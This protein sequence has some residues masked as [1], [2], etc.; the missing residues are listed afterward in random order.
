M[1]LKYILGGA[2]SGKFTKCLEE[3]IYAEKN[4]KKGI[5]IVPNQFTL[6]AE[7]IFINKIDTKVIFNTEIL[8]FKRLAFKI[9]SE[10]GL[11]NKIP[12]ENMG[13]LMILRKIISNLLNNNKLNY[14]SKSSYSNMGVLEKISETIQELLECEIDIENFEKTLENLNKNEKI[15]LETKEKLND[16][17]EIFKEYK[18]F[19]EKDYISNEEILTILSKK[20]K[21]SNLIKEN[22]TIWIYGF[23]GFS[24]QEFNVI[25][26]LAEKVEKINICFNFNEKDIELNNINIF[27]P[28]YNIKKTI[29]KFQIL[30]IEN[31]N[32]TIEPPEFLN[33]NLRHKENF[34][35]N[36]FSQ[37]YFKYKV[38]P[39][40]KEAKNIEIFSAQNKFLEIEKV[41]QKINYLIK[42][43]GYRYN[44]IAIILA[45]LEYKDYLKNIFNKY[46]IPYFL[47]YKKD[48]NSHPLVQMILSIFDIIIYNWRYEDIFKYL[49]S[50]FLTECNKFE[51]SEEDLYNLENYILKYGIKNNLWKKEFKYGFYENS[52]YNKEKL[53][54]TRISILKSLEK[55]DFKNNKKY[56]VLEISQKIFDFLI[57]LD[58]DKTLNKWEE[59]NKKLFYEEI[60]L[61]STAL[62]TNIQTWN[63][64]CQVI[65]KF[66][67]ILGNEEITIEEYLKILKVGFSSEKIGILPPTQDQT[68]IG[69]FERTRLSEIKIL[70]CLGMNEGIIPKYEENK[71]FISETERAILLQNLEL[72]PQ[73]NIKLATD[74]LQI[75]STLFKAKEKIIFSYSI[76][77]LQGKAKK[78]SFIISKISKIFPK[79]Q[80]E[81]IDKIIFEKNNIYS[82]KAMFE[83][84]FN[85]Y[86]EIDKN[87]EDFL[88]F[89]DIFNYFLK[90][91]EYTQNLIKT[92]LNLEK[93]KQENNATINQELIE[94]LYE[95][96][97]VFSSVTKLEQF[98]KC[99]F[100]YFL[101]YNIEAKER[102]ILKFEALQLGK[103]YHYILEDFFKKI[104][105][106]KKNLKDIT[107]LEIFNIIEN[108]MEKIKNT[109]EIENIFNLSQKYNYFFKRIKKI[110]LMS[111][112]ASFEQIKLEEFFPDALELSFGDTDDK[113]NSLEYIE[114]DL[115]NTYKMLLSGKI[116]RVD[117]LKTNEK[118]YYKII[119]Y[120]S[121]ENSL[122]EEEIYYGI[123]LQLFIYLSS[124]IKNKINKNEV[125][126]LPSAVLY[127]QIK[128]EIE[129]TNN[130]ENDFLKDYKFYG[131]I[132][133]NIQENGKIGPIGEISRGKRSS[134]TKLIEEDKFKSLLKLSDTIAKEI[135]Q[136]ITKGNINI[137][138]YKYSKNT[139]CEYCQ[140]KSICK[141]DILKQDYN[142]FKTLSNESIWE[143]I[144]EKIKE[145]D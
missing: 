57:Y 73:S 50:G 37:Q 31:K 4:S 49:K 138:P 16:I 104:I 64:I 87:S 32:I 17:K 18:L 111:T 141:F 97:K 78:C 1:K 145:N 90:D 140:Y 135:G 121:S 44:E 28:F 47:D 117:K 68:L 105:K 39:F 35:L 99:P 42:E 102:N 88:I 6:E 101:K 112:L 79:I 26:A 84:I 103:I 10:M 74:D 20:I 120:K 91:E 45:D 54:K 116:D 56:T 129:K 25:K 48:I 125:E 130:L 126:I 53:N 38:K 12:L 127:F 24:I 71:N 108:S 123:K 43:K 92:K 15:T 109:D 131:I 33:E 106:N 76:S 22:T 98:R 82:K 85:F 40:E 70:F 13:K 3:M 86:K 36:Y 142:Y 144:N 77:N 67:N 143:K 110:A 7:K 51:I 27:D 30:A 11:N 75:Y 93:I 65:E 100:S 136:E 63:K 107:Y 119:D 137:H 34:E 2:G 128:E 96:K 118:E 114:I 113:E 61:N 19:I 66:V 133:K 60:S 81:N 62:D 14:F 29:K 132:E 8:S 83:N 122:K 58:I 59:K 41:A 52:I 72:K 80:I 115:E 9:F 21:Y 69:D 124:L 134:K 89:K 23:N 95:N 139:G 55:F 5:L 94:N 46:N